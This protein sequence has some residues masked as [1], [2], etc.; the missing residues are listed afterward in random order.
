MTW[1]IPLGVAA[2]LGGAGVWFSMRSHRARTRRWLRELHDVVDHADPGPIQSSQDAE[3]VW[4]AFLEH[5]EKARHLQVEARSREVRSTLIGNENRRLQA[6]FGALPTGIAVLRSGNRIL[7]A[8][9]LAVELLQVP[10]QDEPAL[11]AAEGNPRVIGAVRSLLRGDLALGIRSERI[12]VTQPDETVQVYRVRLLEISSSM[13]A[14]SEENIQIVTFEDITS[15]ES[16]QRMKTEFVYGVSHELKTPL[17]SIQASLEMLVEEEELEPDDRQRLLDL[18]YS[19]TIRLGRM[20]RE[21]LDLARVEAGVTEVKRERVV[22]SDLMAE[23]LKVHEPLATRKQ[24]D[25]DWKVSEFVPTVLGDYDLLL[26]AFVNLIG[27]AIK[28]T[29]E[30]GRVQVWAT[31]E[32]EELMVM[33]RDNGIG[34]PAADIDKIFDRFYRAGSAQSSSIPGTGLGLPMARFITETHGGR[35]EVESEEGE[36]S[37]FTAYLPSEEAASEQLDSTDLQSFEAFTGG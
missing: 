4:N 29:R 22:I 25:L 24:I 5:V 3:R 32:G 31:V 17:T 26:Q 27:N 37:T 21:L 36:G 10:D 11:D 34:I 9:T 19:E 35:I 8:N 23:L 18:S 12:E 1:G 14:L 33:V 13:E 6:I 30:S 15:E 16:M 7:Y 20:V 2:L 28:Y